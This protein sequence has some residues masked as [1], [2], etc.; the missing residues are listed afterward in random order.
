MFY[1]IN[2]YWYCNSSNISNNWYWYEIV[3]WGVN[4]KYKYSIVIIFLFLLIYI[5]FGFFFRCKRKY[6][7]EVWYIDMN[8]ILVFVVVVKNLKWF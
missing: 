3:K 5:Y 1:L 8:G 6:K 7:M 4:S 2:V